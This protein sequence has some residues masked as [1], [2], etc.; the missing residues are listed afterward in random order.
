M[1][2]F[3]AAKGLFHLFFSNDDDKFYTDSYVRTDLTF[4]LYDR[5]TAMNYEYI[6]ALSGEGYYNCIFTSLDNISA[7]ALED[8]SSQGRLIGSLF[9]SKR[10]AA[11]N[12]SRFQERQRSGKKTIHLDEM[13]FE[14]NFKNLIAMMKRKS[15]AAVIIPIGIFNSLCRFPEIIDELE[16]INAKNY[17]D[18]NRH[19]FV[20]TS[21]MYAGESIR[22]F[23]PNAETALEGNLFNNSGLFPELEAYYHDYYDASMNFYIYDNLKRLMGDKIIFYNSLS[24]EHIRRMVTRYAIHTEYMKEMSINSI[25]ALTGVIYAYY[26]SAEYRKEHHLSFPENPKRSLSVVETALRNDRSLREASAEAAKDLQ[27]RSD[28]YKYICSVYP[29]CVDSENGIYMI[30]GSSYG[31][32]LGKLIAIKKICMGRYG[33]CPAELDRAIN[34]MSKPCIDTA[35]SFSAANFREK[36]IDIVHKNIVNEL[37]DYVDLDLIQ[38]MLKA[39]NYYFDYFQTSSVL[40][41]DAV[42]AKDLSF[43]FYKNIMHLAERLSNARKSKQELNDKLL[44]MEEQNDMQGIESTR[45][46]LEQTEAM[47]QNLER[48]IENAENILSS[49]LSEANAR[50]VIS[51]MKYENQ[52]LKK[53]DTPSNKIYN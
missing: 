42:T 15:K 19:I 28:I 2:M 25:N 35:V 26:Q 20:I 27:S 51:G 13:N 39:L 47:I 31:E 49:P 45:G 36:V 33:E 24:F 8:R 30:G 10:Q 41:G 23:K 32:D 1:Q 37:T 5:L 12:S 53:I 3:D 9:G 29:D 43:D 14:E 11:E 18:N 6:Y 21:S 17:Q 44:L 22:F 52:N 38:F 46:Y 40:K 48:T 7:E 34:M 16:R 50:S 4:H